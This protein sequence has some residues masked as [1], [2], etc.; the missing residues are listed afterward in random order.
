MKRFFFILKNSFKELIFMLPLFLAVIGL[1]GLFQVFVSKDLLASFFSGNPV[2]D[3][4]SGTVAGAVAVGQAIVSYIIGGE[5]L[6]EG[7]SMYAV[8]SFILAWVTLGIVQLPAEA[9][10]LSVK[11]TVY[12]NLLSFIFTIIVSVSVVLT[13]KS[14]N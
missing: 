3:T 5:L 13:L 10:I 11:F 9:E 1:V 4:L 7:V 12:R 2:T 8:S 6:K 14:I